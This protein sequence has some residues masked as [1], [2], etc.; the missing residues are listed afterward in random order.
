MADAATAEGTQ[1]LTAEE[2][3]VPGAVDVLANN[4]GGIAA[5]AARSSS[6][7]RGKPTVGGPG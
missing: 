5:I 1:R 3:E 6:H 2:G 7:D 4:G